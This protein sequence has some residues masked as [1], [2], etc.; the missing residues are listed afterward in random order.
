LHLSR[1]VHLNPVHAGLVE[2]PEAWEYSSY[3]EYIGLRQGTLVHPGRVLSQFASQT[4]GAFQ[5]PGVS[6]QQAYGEFVAAYT[7]NEL[8]FIRDLTLDE[9]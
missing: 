1:Y 7:H 2:T 5:A 6:P 3:R 4:R 9:S 8:R